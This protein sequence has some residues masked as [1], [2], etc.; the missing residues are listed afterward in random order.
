MPKNLTSPNIVISN[1]TLD[2]W[3]AVTPVSDTAAWQWTQA[4]AL[5][6]IKAQK[7]GR[8]MPQP[9]IPTTLP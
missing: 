8:P 5:A 1:A 4:Q 7:A 3:I 2:Q 6:G 9:P